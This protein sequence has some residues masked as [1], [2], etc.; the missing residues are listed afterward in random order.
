MPFSYHEAIILMLMFSG[1][2]ILGAWMMWEY[3]RR[4]LCT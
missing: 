3:N 1:G 4:D 2:M